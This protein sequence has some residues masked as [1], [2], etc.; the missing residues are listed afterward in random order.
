M[1]RH[2]LLYCTTFGPQSPFMEILISAK[3]PGP[4][5]AQSVMYLI[6]T[7][8]ISFLFIALC[9]SSRTFFTTYSTLFHSLSI[10]HSNTY[11]SGI[12]RIS[13]CRRNVHDWRRERA[14]LVLGLG[15]FSLFLCLSLSI[16]MY[17]YM[18]GRCST[19]SDWLI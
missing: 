3:Y 12:S 15:R 6:L 9:T 5:G 7:F 1:F 8:S 4:D 14:N 11:E 2:V 13:I 17:I 16:Y 18:Y 19:Q 10:S